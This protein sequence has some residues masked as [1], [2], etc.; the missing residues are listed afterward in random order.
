VKLVEFT[1]KK[2]S[3]DVSNRAV[4]EVVQP[5]AH[6]E[7]VDVSHLDADSFA[8]FVCDYKQLKN[9]QHQAMA[10]LMSKHDLT[11]NYRRFTPA[12][13]TNVVSEHI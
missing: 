10:E 11:H 3:G 5:S 2:A 12:N 1:Y 8:S 13:M 7:G 4:V 6:F 9:A